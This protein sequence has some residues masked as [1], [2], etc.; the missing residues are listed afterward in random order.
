[1]YEKM[2]V[3]AKGIAASGNAVR[4][5]H[6]L[7]AI[8]EQTFGLKIMVPSHSEEAAFGAAL[9]ALAACGRFDSLYEACEALIRYIGEDREGYR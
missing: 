1:M 6:L 2:G 8:L 9:F 5:N 4:K 7:R 3:K